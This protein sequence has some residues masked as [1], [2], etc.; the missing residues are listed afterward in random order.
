M[1]KPEECP[2]SAGRVPAPR[3]TGYHRGGM[4]RNLKLILAY[5]G[6]EFHGWQRQ[7]SGLRTVQGEVEAVLQRILRHPLSLHGAS[8]TD[9][10][11]HARGQVAS[12]ITTSPIPAENLARA[13][14]HHLPR[15]IALA[16]VCVRPLG[17]HASRDA[18]GKL[19]RYRIFNS[20]RRPTETLAERFVWHVWYPLDVDAMQAA[21]DRLVGTHD[22]VS[23]A[24]AGSPRR[25]TV[26]T[27]RRMEVARRGLEVRIDVEGDGFLYNQ[28]RNMVGTLVEIGR[29][30]WEPGIISEILAARDRSRAA[31]TAPPQ[32]LC[33]QWV[34][35]RR[36]RRP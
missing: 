5:D 26:R 2:T 23:F 28:V 33:L 21:A 7:T 36:R 11:V 22:F 12:V 18:C 14:G 24:T 4:E 35:Y 6:G 1:G 15:D 3:L 8:R 34:R 9:T 32:G 13:I 29:G 20:I 27:I 31:P 17:F 16:H 25:T 19:Y 30:R 10:G